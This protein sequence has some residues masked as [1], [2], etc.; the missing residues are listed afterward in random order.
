MRILGVCPSCEAFDAIHGDP[1]LSPEAV[2]C[3]RCQTQW[4]EWQDL[5]TGE[6]RMKRRLIPV[7]IFV[8]RSG[9][10]LLL[11]PKTDI[12]WKDTIALVLNAAL[13]ARY[14]R[15]RSNLSAEGGVEGRVGR[16]GLRSVELRTGSS[17]LLG[18]EREEPLYLGDPWQPSDWVLRFYARLLRQ[19]FEE[20]LRFRRTTMRP[21]AI[22]W[23]EPEGADSHIEAWKFLALVLQV[24]GGA[25]F[26]TKVQEVLRRLHPLEKMH[27]RG[28]SDAELRERFVPPPWSE[29][30]FDSRES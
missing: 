6:R 30:L 14:P 18:L 11:P 10:E 9:V 16:R 26:P 25:Q 21:G 23:L 7:S 22:L 17:D 1:A 12:P 28:P 4:P 24:T 15:L 20:P 27:L 3:H 8:R 19:L 5:V 13:L 29:H 2:R